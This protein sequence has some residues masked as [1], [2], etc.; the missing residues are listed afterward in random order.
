MAYP[1]I[2]LCA[3]RLKSDLP[4]QEFYVMNFP[5]EAKEVIRRITAKRDK[6]SIDKTALPVKSLY[7]GLRLVP[8]LI[9]LGNVSPKSEEFWLYS[10]HPLDTKKL[11]AILSYWIDIEY[12]D[13]P[14]K[15]G[16][17]GITAQERQLAMS[18]LS[19]D[20]L[21]WEKRE[22]SYTNH[23]LTH[24][25]GTANLSSNDFIL[26]PHILATEL[27]KPG[28]E[29]EVDGEKLQFYRT[30]PSSGKGAEL[31][32]WHPLNYTEDGQIYYYS[33]VLKLRM[34]L[35][36]NL[37]YPRL[38][39]KPSIRRWLSIKDSQL[40]KSH[41]SNA[42]IRAKLNWGQALNPD[43][44]TEY[45]LPCR[46]VLKNGV[47][48]WDENLAILLKKLDI[49][50][51]TPQQILANYSE[52]LIGNPNIGITYKEGMK[53]KHKVAKGLPTV[54]TH[55][56]LSQIADVL[57]Y[58]WQP[59]DCQRKDY[60][61]NKQSSQFFDLK[62]PEKNFDEPILRKKAETDKQ[63]AARKK[64]LLRKQE[65]ELKKCVKKKRESESDYQLRR[66][67]LLKKQE[68][69]HLSWQPN[70]EETEK[71]FQLRL[72]Q[73]YEERSSEQATLR[74][75]IRSSVG[76]HLTIWIWYINEENLVERLKAIKYCLGLPEAAP[77]SYSFPEG[78][79][80]A[81][82]LHEVAG[83]AQRLDLSPESKPNSTEREKAIK[84]RRDEIA[85]LVQPVKSKLAGKVG[86]W[87]ELYEKNY[88]K[89]VEKD[90]EGK[91]N[92][93]K[94]LLAPWG[95]PKSSIRLGF[96]DEGL[97]S[98]FI[99]PEQ[100]NY[101]QKAICSF[102]DL[103]R[104]LGVRMAP[105]H[106]TLPKVN[107]DTPIN[108]VGLWLVNRTSET[109]GDGKPQT[110]PVIV[111]MS[112]LTAE[113]SAIFPGLESWIPY[114]EALTR[115]NKEGEGFTNDDKGKAKIRTFIQ[116]TLNKKEL[117]GKPT[118][119]YC[120]AQNI[121][122]QWTWLQ[123]TQISVK[124]LSFAERDKPV[125]EEFAGLRVIRLRSGDETSE[126]FGMDGEKVS[127]FIT[128]LFKNLDN[129]RVFFSIG[130]KPST[131]SDILKDLSR[132]EQP[133]KPWVHPSLVEIAIGYYQEDDKDNL[134][135]LAAIAH[136][137]RHGVL[138][139]EDFLEVPRVLHYAKQMADYVLM[140]DDDDDASD[141]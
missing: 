47:A 38:D 44:L 103:L 137:S 63:F 4:T 116:E 90:K 122:Q 65:T 25:N 37:H 114:D 106:I 96:A 45:L 125:F 62:K 80:V 120:L 130:K 42:Y 98:K 73:F 112:S 85:A 41:G 5:E 111:K 123:D 104:S 127:G 76:E 70:L 28:L 7:K 99:T 110:I 139:Y 40:S 60:K 91:E 95:D 53:P 121:R 6:T 101:C 59:I 35:E 77:G 88:W 22:V 134:L 48:N 15:R 109:S 119:L 29:F 71:A 135:D 108:E 124:G 33:I 78:L 31:I 10:S 11:S 21:V 24:P 8:G 97:I 56:L 74:R 66:E 100:K 87:F 138:Q 14:C 92:E 46:M 82:C 19:A 83:L 72:E 57:K 115:I 94:S 67:G 50:S 16:K 26:L 117:R 36:P 69:E 131:M 64:R 79:T 55:E 39:V 81:I 49:L 84:K 54:N 3:F 128:G 51:V 126:W 34:V 133:G 12:P 2:R 18:Y 17:V 102:I 30:I 68:L 9:H 75:A 86:V 129:D 113:I 27:T 1:T 107:K 58:Y 136:E 43:E 105:S 93:K 32:S 61:T 118:L 89:F 20:K 140:L 141:N 132:I 23:F 13:E 52:A